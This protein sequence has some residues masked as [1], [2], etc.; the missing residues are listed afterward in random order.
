[1]SETSRDRTF[2]A[3]VKLIFSSQII[4]KIISLIKIKRPL[5]N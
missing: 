2:K 5:C 1:M 4:V 3:A